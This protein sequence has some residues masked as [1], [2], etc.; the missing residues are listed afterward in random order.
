[1]S[2]HHEL[3]DLISRQE[4]AYMLGIKP[5]TLAAWAVKGWYDGVLPII[6]IHRGLV[7]YRRSDVERFIQS[8]ASNYDPYATEPSDHV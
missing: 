7:R 5:A 6:R 1:M 3:P 8:R 2:N 4:A